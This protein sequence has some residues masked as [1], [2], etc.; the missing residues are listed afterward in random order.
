[1][2]LPSLNTLVACKNF[3]HDRLVLCSFSEQLHL[4][5]QINDCWIFWEKERKTEGGLIFD[6]AMSWFQ[7][8]EKRYRDLTAMTLWNSG[9]HQETVRL[10]VRGDCSST[11]LP[12]SYRNGCSF[13]SWQGLGCLSS[14]KRS[15][16]WQGPWS[17]ENRNGRGKAGKGVTYCNV[18]L[19]YK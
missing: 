15:A 3:F 7:H 6:C 13:P 8:V 10:S 2:P 16:S 12:L 19:V 1:M 17:C 11:L 9:C 14:T 4:M 18:V 5:L